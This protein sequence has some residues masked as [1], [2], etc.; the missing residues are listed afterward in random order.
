MK[1]Q[2]NLIFDLGLHRGLDSLFYLKKGF[3]VVALEAVEALCKTASENNQEAVD[4]GRLK[5]INRALYH[6]SDETV[7]FFINPDKDDWGSL[8]K[9]AAEKGVGQAYE[10]KVNTITLDD[11]FKKY[12]Y[13]YYIKCDLEGGDA[14]FVQQA[15]VAPYKPPFVSVEATSSDDLAILR[16]CGYNRFQIINQ[17][18]NPYT[19][20]PT[21]SREGRDVDQVFTHEMSGLFGRDL[22]PN[23]WRPFADVMACFLD[24]YD[25]RRRNPQLAVGWLDVHA[26]K[27]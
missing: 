23:D 20:C 18:L 1:M 10:V 22:P 16:A 3:D 26:T 2:P 12:G 6:A 17:Y 11:I 24:W 4:N 14:I 19:K 7:S 27:V 9:G 25:L 13:P 15:L 5:I 21:P 8:E